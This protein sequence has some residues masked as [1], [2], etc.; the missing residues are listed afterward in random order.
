MTLP[1]CV[2]EPDRA[3]MWTG[4]LQT[5]GQHAN[6]ARHGRADIVMRFPDRGCIVEIKYR[7]FVAK[8]LVQ[9]DERPYALAEMGRGYPVA[10]VGLN[11]MD[12]KAME[13]GHVNLYDPD[14]WNP[15][16]QYGLRPAV[17]AAGGPCGRSG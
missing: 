12:R 4:P 8:A 2:A 9:I 3:C 14:P 16:R 10:G 7:Q 13:M 1:F 15:R 11:F 17:C 6:H 5:A